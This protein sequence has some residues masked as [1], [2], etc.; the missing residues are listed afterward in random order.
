[1]DNFVLGLFSDA[2]DRVQSDNDSNSPPLASASSPTLSATADSPD[3]SASNEAVDPE[4]DSPEQQAKNAVLKRIFFGMFCFQ[5][6]L[7]LVDG[8]LPASLVQISDEIS[9]SYIEVSCTFF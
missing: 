4:D 6:L 5:I 2:A 9:L 3:R 8:C 7:N 1:L